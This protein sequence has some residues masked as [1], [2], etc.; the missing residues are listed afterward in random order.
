MRNGLRYPNQ[1]LHAYLQHSARQYPDRD[2]I[3]YYDG[4][5]CRELSRLSYAALD[6]LSDRFALA[7]TD[8][9]VGKGD[10]V[11]YFL[12]NSP[13]LVATFYGIL[14]AGAVA[15]P[16]NPMYLGEELAHQLA[17]SGA[18]LVVCVADLLHI[19]EGIRARAGVERVVVVGNDC[20]DGF[21]H[22][23]APGRRVGPLP[24]VDPEG[25]M[26]LLCYTGGTTGV[27]MTCP[28]KTGPVINS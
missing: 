5:A 13:Q 4:D 15:V 7:L 10:R 17:D 26:A 16:C 22:M 9:G 6:G 12:Q 20:P 8:M 25:D 3:I 21:D 24:E 19:V 18:R 1:P 14:K 23:V 28:P 27:P 2:A 11:A